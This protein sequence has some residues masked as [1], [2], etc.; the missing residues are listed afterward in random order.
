MMTIKKTIGQMIAE[1]AK[2]HQNRDALV[3]TETGTRCNTRIDT[4]RNAETGTC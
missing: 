4:R 1:I 2:A 3:H